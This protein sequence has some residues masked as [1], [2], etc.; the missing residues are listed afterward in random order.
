MGLS[1]EFSRMNGL[2]TFASVLL[3]ANLASSQYVLDA[4]KNAAVYVKGNS[5]YL[6]HL[7]SAESTDYLSVSGLMDL[8][9]T[10]LNEVQQLHRYFRA[11]THLDLSAYNTQVQ[12][13]CSGKS[14]FVRTH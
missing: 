2:L 7:N 5:C 11:D 4:T 6:F 1:S 12:T 9:T 14:M 13:I 3:I 8:Q 10:F